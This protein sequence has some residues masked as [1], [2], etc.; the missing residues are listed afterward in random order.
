MIARPLWWRR[1]LARFSP[2][3]ALEIVEGDS[4]PERLPRRNLILAREDGEDWCV[5]LHCPCGC[6]E[7]LEMM[8]LGNVA[9]RWDVQLDGKGRVSLHPSVWRRVGCR[10]HFWVKAGKIVWCE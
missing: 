3:R 4:L 7:R 9:P 6:G 2:R 8:T 5:G 10:S 1:L